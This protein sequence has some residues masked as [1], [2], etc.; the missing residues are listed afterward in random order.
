MGCKKMTDGYKT[1]NGRSSTG[2]GSRRKHFGGLYDTY[3]GNDFTSMPTRA[4]LPS[5]RPAVEQDTDPFE[6]SW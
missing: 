4:I 1:E 2:I 5:E 6:S 3:F